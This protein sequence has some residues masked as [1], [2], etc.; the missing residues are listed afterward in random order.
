[1]TVPAS[2]TTHPWVTARK[3]RITFGLFTLPDPDWDQFVAR[4]RWAEQAGFDACAL[5]DHPAF[6]RDCWTNLTGIAL[7]TERIR[8]TVL[9]SCVFYRY[10]GLLARLAAD[11]D[12]L[13]GGRLVL[14]LG[15]GNAVAE[16]DRLGIPYPG[17]AERLRAMAETVQILDGAWGETPFTF[18][19]EQFRT[20]ELHITPGPVQSRRVPIIIA[21][22]GE[23]VT[24]RQ[25]AQYADASNFGPSGGAGSAYEITDVRRKLD[26]LRRHCEEVGRPYDSILRTHAVLSGCVLLA[27]TEARARAKAEARPS[28][29]GMWRADPVYGTPEQV[30]AQYRA[31]AAEGL[32][33]FVVTFRTGDE[34]S[35]HLFVEQVM[36]A[37]VGSRRDM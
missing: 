29:Q 31:L 1:M 14:G 32:E 24:L 26:A 34:E 13:S 9:V 15:T 33:H 28:G 37:L 4:V 27:P 12:R 21:G 36:P 2:W 19:G 22:G 17:T 23:R 3:G 25:V 6:F 10:P 35:R 18:V 30:I 8:L 11:V 20:E 7:A 16:F 5:P